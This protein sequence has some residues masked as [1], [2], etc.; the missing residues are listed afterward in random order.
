[1][2]DTDLRYGSVVDEALRQYNISFTKADFFADYTNVL[3]KVY[4]ADGAVYGLKICRDLST[5]I[6]DNL[7]EA[8]FLSLFSKEED[9]LVPQVIKNKYGLGVSFVSSAYFEQP[10]RTILYKWVEG[11][12]FEKNRTATLFFELGKIIGKMHK[13]TD[14]ITMPKD[15]KAKIWNRMF[16]FRDEE[17]VYKEER[18]RDKFGSKGIEIYENAISFVNE[19]LSKMINKYPLR[20]LHGDINPWNVLVCEDK[21]GII[22]FE[23]CILGYPAQDIAIL[24]YYYRYHE[25]Y[26]VFKESLLKGYNSEIPSAKFDEFELELLIM[27]RRLNFINLIL[28]IED[29]PSEYINT[30]LK[31]AEEFMKEH[32]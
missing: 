16:Y 22:D 17:V 30:S 31:R 12:V 5:T 15:L 1:M 7:C 27:A 9:F 25:E 24:L 14:G 11:K 4:D 13:A 18:Y 20:L 3:Y 21:L 32:S 19:H 2:G 6:E 29:N 28:L 8:F 23:D 10:R 26:E